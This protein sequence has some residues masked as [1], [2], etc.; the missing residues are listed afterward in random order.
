M[1]LLDNI[2]T[3][4]SSVIT[5]K[6]AQNSVDRFKDKYLFCLDYVLTEFNMVSTISDRLLNIFSS[7]VNIDEFFVAKYNETIKGQMSGKIQYGNIWHINVFFNFTYTTDADALKFFNNVFQYT[8]MISPNLARNGVMTS[9]IHNITLS[10]SDINGKVDIHNS[11]INEVSKIW[12]IF[13]IESKEDQ[14]ILTDILYLLRGQESE[15]YK[16]TEREMNRMGWIN[17]NHYDLYSVYRIPNGY[18]YE[19]K[20]QHNLSEDIIKAKRHPQKSP[21][22][23]LWEANQTH[24]LFINCES[25]ILKGRSLRDLALRILLMSAFIEETKF[26]D[27]PVFCDSNIISI[28][29]PNNAY[30]FCMKGA[31]YK[32]RRWNM[33]AN[34]RDMRVMN[35]YVLHLYDTH[36]IEINYD[37]RSFASELCD[38]V[39]RTTIENIRTFIKMRSS[40]NEFYKNIIL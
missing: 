39:N 29:T 15:D 2:G 6:V 27:R 35:D 8:N 40:V 1:S 19:Y 4:D 33:T 14:R 13:S 7:C 26:D 32:E 22:I 25:A 18:S 11:T 28:R 37:L 17:H 12:G 20:Y 31:Y 34:L 30:E 21:K 38:F 24:S 23:D 10:R 3:T 36:T 5:K 9:V 16:K